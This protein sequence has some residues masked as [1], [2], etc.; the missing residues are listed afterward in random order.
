MF[1]RDT[2]PSPSII[3]YI[4]GYVK[5]QYAFWYFWLIFSEFWKKIILQ[6][7]LTLE[8]ICARITQSLPQRASEASP[9]WGG[10]QKFL[11]PYYIQNIHLE[12]TFYLHLEHTFI[13]YIYN[14]H[15]AI[16]ALLAHCA[17]S[18]FTHTY[19]STST[20]FLLPT[21]PLPFGAFHPFTYIYN[22]HL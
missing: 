3:P 4:F 20:Y 5:F 12:H 17:R 6:K 15:L 11:G 9:I 1:A 8:K 7:N 13:N 10:K 19:N 21:A 18:H 22:I 16:H 2:Y 14:F